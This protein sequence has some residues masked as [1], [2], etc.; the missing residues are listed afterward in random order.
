MLSPISLASIQSRKPNGCWDLMGEKWTLVSHSWSSTTTRPLAGLI[1]WT[2]T[3]TST[4]LPSAQRSGGGPSLHTAWIKHS[5]S[6][7]H[8]QAHQGSPERDQRSFRRLLHDWKSVPC[9]WSSSTLP[10]TS[11]RFCCI[12][13]SFFFNFFICFI[14]CPLWHAGAPRSAVAHSGKVCLL[15]HENKTRMHQVQGWTT[16]QMFLQ[17]PHK[18][19]YCSDQPFWLGTKLLGIGYM[20]SYLWFFVPLDNKLTNGQGLSFCHFVNVRDMLF[21]FGTFWLKD[22]LRNQE[23]IACN[24]LVWCHFRV[25]IRHVNER[26]TVFILATLCSW[27]NVWYNSAVRQFVRLRNDQLEWHSLFLTR[28]HALDM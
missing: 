17:V 11:S 16:W 4:A 2:R 19:N 8:A 21:Y 7:E 18:V 20:L 3:L 24:D 14:T 13:A 15:R 28:I 9:P 23:M 27:Q 5:A 6:L 26:Y 22:F 10:R 1:G 25:C 12:S